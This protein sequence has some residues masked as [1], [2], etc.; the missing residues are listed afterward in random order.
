MT[1]EQARAEARRRWGV[2][3]TAR[4]EDAGYVVG[5]IGGDMLPNGTYAYGVGRSWEEAFSDSERRARK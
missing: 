2:A 3:G 1:A 5:T 4:I